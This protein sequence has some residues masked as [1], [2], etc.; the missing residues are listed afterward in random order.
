MNISNVYKHRTAS[1]LTRPHRHG[2]LTRREFLK[3]GA[4][5]AAAAIA[6]GFDGPR[7]ARAASSS[8]DPRPIPYGSAFLGPGS[9]F[10]V[11]APGYPLPSPPFNVNPATADPSTITDF[12]GFVGLTYVGGQGTHHNLVT[13][14]TEE[15]YWEVD[16]R[17]MVGEYVGKDGRHHH[18]TFGFV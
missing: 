16:L 12:N 14:A 6:L 2:A 3:A 10:H 8:A 9:L 18:G 17:F 1:L 11:E 13:G 4:G 15:M 5:A 7:A